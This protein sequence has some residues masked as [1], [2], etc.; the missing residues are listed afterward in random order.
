M[1]HMVQLSNGISVPA[2]GV[3]TW[4]LAEAREKESSE[5][6]AV[7]AGI[8]QGMTLVDTAEM[9]GNGRSESL[10]GRAIAGMDRE[11]LFLVSKVL[12]HNAGRRQIFSSCKNSL[13]RLGTDY[14]DLY[15]L[16]WRGPI[17]LSE[18][19]ACMEELKQQGL[20]LQWGVSNFDTDD[21][22]ELWQVKDGQNCLVNQVLYHMGSRGIE[23]DLLPWMK[24]H[25]VA[26]MAYCPL[27]QGGSLRWGLM[28]NPTVLEIAKAKGATPAQ[29]LLAWAIRDGST[30]AIP[31]SSSPAHAEENAQADGLE[32]SS[33]EVRRIDSC[34]PGPSRKMPLDIQ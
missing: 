24:A 9:Y 20:I 22:E 10:V 3:G 31:K 25:H 14:L 4:H 19:V 30:I 15:L 1:K 17:P 18:T 2:L 28:T 34:Y 33:D 13:K 11:K 16:H 8:R 6:A 32:L 27:A 7:R 23:Y 12:P 5:L 26:L 29:V 21:M